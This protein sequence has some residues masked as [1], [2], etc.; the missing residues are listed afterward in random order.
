MNYPSNNLHPSS[1]LTHITFKE[2]NPFSLN[3]RQFPNFETAPPMRNK[4]VYTHKK[5]FSWI[6]TMCK[7]I[8]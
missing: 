7:I 6:S 2:I 3:L 8:V 1:H 4:T 5:G